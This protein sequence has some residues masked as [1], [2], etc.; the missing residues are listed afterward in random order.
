MDII[1]D[2]KKKTLACYLRT[3]GFSAIW[4]QKKNVGENLYHDLSDDLY[5]EGVNIRVYV[6][7][8]NANLLRDFGLYIED[9]L[10][11]KILV[12]NNLDIKRDDLIIIQTKEYKVVDTFSIENNIAFNMLRGY[13]IVLNR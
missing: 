8:H 10:P 11:I 1:K 12:D 7:A 9:S 3:F 6:Y 13:Y 2:I 4:K 5:E